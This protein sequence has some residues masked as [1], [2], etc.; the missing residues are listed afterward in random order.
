VPVVAS[1]LAASK[2][3]AAASIYLWAAPFAL[4]VDLLHIG[5]FGGPFIAA[6]IYLGAIVVPAIFWQ[7]AARRNCCYHGRGWRRD[8]DFYVP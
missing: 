8:R 2:H 7:I 3:R 5:A 1:V 6:L 4:F